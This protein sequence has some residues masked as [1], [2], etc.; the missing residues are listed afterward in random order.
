MTAD[1]GNLQTV[2]FRAAAVGSGDGGWCCGI[3]DG[4]YDSFDVRFL[5][6][7]T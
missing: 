1:A 2:P 4:N 5:V 6:N 7:I 3:K